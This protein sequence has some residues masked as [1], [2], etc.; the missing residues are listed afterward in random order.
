MPAELADHPPRGIR[1]ER[2]AGGRGAR[3][4][5]H[6]YAVARE[7]TVERDKH[8]E[9]FTDADVVR[10]RQTRAAQILAPFAGWLGVQHRSTTP[11]SLFGQGVGY[12]RNQ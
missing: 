9:T 1:S 3:L 11:K 12:A 2:P 8:G 5:P 4:R 7:I 10:V 6:L